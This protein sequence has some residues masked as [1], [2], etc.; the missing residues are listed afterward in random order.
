ME[1]FRK[2]DSPKLSPRRGKESYMKND[3]KNLI[4]REG[5]LFIEHLDSGM[6]AIKIG[7]GETP[8]EKLPYFMNPREDVLRVI[9]EREERN[10]N[11]LKE[12]VLEEDLKRSKIAT[13]KEKVK[14]AT[15]FVVIICMLFLAY[16]GAIQAPKDEN[17]HFINSYVHTYEIEENSTE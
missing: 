5:E 13:F 10:C 14:I 8:Y 17:S 7:D 15:Y 12:L 9:M 4:L 1:R 3:G 16:L 6:G 11:S 2:M